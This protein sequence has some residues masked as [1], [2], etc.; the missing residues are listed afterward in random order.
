MMV[1]GITIRPCRTE[2]CANVLDLW[3]KAEATPSTTD[4]VQELMT[5]IEAARD[6]GSKALVPL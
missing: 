3:Q 5:L 2:E 4:S 1:A 6:H